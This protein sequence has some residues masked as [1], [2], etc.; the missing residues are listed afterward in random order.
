MVQDDFSPIMQ[1]DTGAPFNPV[2]VSKTTGNPIN[3]TGATITMR[4]QNQDTG[5]AQNC[6]GTWTIDNDPTSGKAYYAYSSADVS[7]PGLWDM[8]I[9]ITI[10][11]KPVHADVKVLQILPAI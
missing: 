6:T 1:N 2:F 11:S 9:D 10:N 5:V 3:L 7:T 4:M 8:S